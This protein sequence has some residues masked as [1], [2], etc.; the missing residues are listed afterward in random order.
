MAI[1]EPLLFFC[2]SIRFCA[3]TVGELRYSV[4]VLSE[5]LQINCGVVQFDSLSSARMPS[6]PP[7]HFNYGFFTD[8]YFTKS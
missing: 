7:V 2:Y 6:H 4:I 3:D 1:Q 5:I 8:C